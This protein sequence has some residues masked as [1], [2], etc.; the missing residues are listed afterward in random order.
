MN[1]QETRALRELGR[2][3]WNDW[4]AQILKSKAN[5]QDVGALSL[6]WFGEGEND[7]TRLWLKVASAD[8]S[9]EHFEDEV[10]FEGF[11]FPGPVNFTGAVF[12]RPVF[13]TGAEFQLP[14]KFAHSLFQQDACFKGAA[15]AG[16]AVFDDATFEGEADFEG[17]EFQKERNGPLTHGVKFQ[18]ARF[19]A[20][21]DFRST[22]LT[23]SSDFSKVQFAGTARFDSA[24][25]ATDTVFEGAIFSGPAGFN[26]CEF[27]GTATFQEAQFTGEARFSEAVFKSPCTFDRTQFWSDLSFREARFEQTASFADMRLEGV[28]RF[29]GAKFAMQAHF[30]EAR[31]GGNADFSAVDFAGPAIFRFARLDHGGSWSQCRF[32]N[33]ADFSGLTLGRNSSFKESRF[34]GNAFFKEAR[35]EAPVSFASTHFE[36]V[37]D[38]SAV[39]SKVAFVLAGAEF[40]NVPS[41]LEA[42]FHEPPRVDHMLVAD[43]LKR[44]HSWKAAGLSDPRG[45][46][47]RLMK[48]CMDPDA[49]AK[50][51]RLKKLAFEAQDQTREQEFFA[52]ELRC[53]RF[54]YDKPFGRGVARFWLGWFYGGVANF[55]RSLLRPVTLWLLLIALFSAYYLGQRPSVH[56]DQPWAAA[57]HVPTQASFTQRS[58]GNVFAAESAPCVTGNSN[59]VGEA[60]YLSLRNA[61]LKLDWDD[62]GTARR[63]FGCL[64]GVE[65]SGN[66]IIPLSVSA[67]SLFQSMLSAGL[68]FMFLLALR[69]LLKV[70]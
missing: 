70:R 35:F 44:L 51:R 57:S 66:S 7:E 64:Y 55:G 56:S 2:D 6:N 16:Q 27:A 15:F 10:D 30:L 8:F 24:K 34:E 36:S 65:I 52:Q 43:P 60:L 19:L 21:A 38:F 22:V 31:F 48:V 49:S 28:S 42:S 54:W 14:A 33:E 12:E 32:M 13:F 39:Q 40:R 68:I 25:F 63:V 29:R 37:A 69:N 67:V 1:G 4:A 23:G 47:F 53:R 59:P 20:R 50:F 62:V 46:F 3:A 9:S 5:F 17:A 26:A 11:I 45:I 41:F 61:M 58:F 18:R